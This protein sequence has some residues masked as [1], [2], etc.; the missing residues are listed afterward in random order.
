MKTPQSPFDVVIIGAGIIGS[1]IAHIAQ[2]RGLN[3]ALLGINKVGQVSSSA[4]GI[5]RDHVFNLPTRKI[6]NVAAAD[7]QTQYKDLSTKI[8]NEIGLSSGFKELPMVVLSESEHQSESF[9]ELLKQS[10]NDLN[11]W[12]LLTPEQIREKVPQLRNRPYR[13]LYTSA[14]TLIDSQLL[15]DALYLMITKHGGWVNRSLHAVRPIFENNRTVGVKAIQGGKSWNLETQQVVVATGIWSTELLPK[16]LNI[17]IT[18]KYAH[19]LKVPN[20]SQ[21]NNV[22][23]RDKM[24]IIPLDSNH[25]LVTSIEQP[26]QKHNTDEAYYRQYLLD[27][28]TQII[29]SQKGN[30]VEQHSISHLSA[31]PDGLPVVGKTT[32]DGLQLA[33]GHDALGITLACETASTIVGNIIDKTTTNIDSRFSPLRYLEH[34]Q[35]T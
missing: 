35:V 25:L 5:V 23:V 28:I 12:Q 20:T 9:D 6:G 33:T 19:A 13:S 10:L 14:T 3:A 8:L 29:P 11:Q 32:V 24:T 18:Q 27:E 15:C 26:T 30:T 16:T 34:T 31:T 4:V 7:S 21:L 22:I 17:P 1:M 2:S